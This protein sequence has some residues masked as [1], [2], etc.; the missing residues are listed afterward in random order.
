MNSWVVTSFK[1]FKFKKFQTKYI[2]SY[3][4]LF[5]LRGSV[6]A[7]TSSVTD[8]GTIAFQDSYYGD[9]LVG[10]TQPTL[11]GATTC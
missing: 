9:D 2:K 4:I 5:I 10:R 1:R 6:Y 7:A 11:P 8:G 3:L